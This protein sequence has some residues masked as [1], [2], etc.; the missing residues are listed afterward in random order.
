MGFKP[1]A[2]KQAKRYTGAP[3][4][5]APDGRSSYGTESWSTDAPLDSIPELV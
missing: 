1:E 5:P 2:R 3:V 4:A